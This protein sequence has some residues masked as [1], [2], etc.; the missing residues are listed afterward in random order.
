MLLTDEPM[1]AILAEKAGVDRIFYDLEYINK[2]ERQAGRNAVMSKY[3]IKGISKVRKSIQRTS[4][5]VRVNPIY[6]GSEDE[7]NQAIEY[8][9]DILMLPMVLDAGDVRRFLNLVG[10]RA[11]TCIM[12]ETPQSLVRLDEILEIEGIDEIFVGLNDLHIG[13]GLT[14]MFEIL[15]GGIL[16]YI[17]EKCKARNIS[18]GFGGIARIGDGMLPAEN[19]IGE[20]Y[21]LKSTTVILSRAFKNCS[22]PDGKPNID[23]DFTCEIGKIRAQEVKCQNWT[24]KEFLENKKLVYEKVHNVVD[25]IIKGKE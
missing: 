5:L 11:K 4:L 6:F 21:R 23:F 19:I 18:F 15:S 9:A 10:G 1:V 17:S 12:I 25:N 8:G 2:R 16:D 24:E 7:I 3:D 20:H 22:S 14:F 13:M